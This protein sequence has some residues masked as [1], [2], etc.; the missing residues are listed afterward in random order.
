M[1]TEKN[2]A[3]EFLL[4]E[5]NGDR[6]REAILIKAGN[7]LEPGT[8][9]GEITAEPGVYAPYAEANNDG[10]QTAKAVLFAAIDT[11]SEG[12]NADTKALVIARDATVD[13]N[14]LFGHDAPGE[15]DLNGL[16][17]IVRS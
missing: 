3:G 8:L 7:T 17:I 15:V 5:A 11:S 1:L 13:L 12:T 10:T 6:S 9:L 16:G 14:A 2:H 4:S